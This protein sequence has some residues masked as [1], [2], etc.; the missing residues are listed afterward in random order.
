MI[1]KTYPVGGMGC[2]ACAARVEKILANSNGVIEVAVNYAAATAR[3]VVEDG[4][5]ME[6]VAGAVADGG[7]KLFTDDDRK[8]AAADAKIRNYRRLKYNTLFACL[9]AFP[10]MMI[11]MLWMHSVI[12]LYIQLILSTLV[13]FCFGR[14]FFINSWKQLRHFTCSMDTLVALSTGIA[15]LFS[16]SNMFWPG[17]WLKHGIEPHVYFEAA[18]VIIAFILIGRTL[19]AHAKQTTSA[20]IERLNGLQ[21]DYVTVVTSD[22]T[23]IQRYVS[24]IEPGDVVRILPGEGIPVDGIITQGDSAVDE[25][26]LTGEPIPVEKHVGDR[27]FCGTINGNGTLLCEATTQAGETLLARIIR[28]VED[29]QGTKP[30]VQK[31]VDKIASIFVPT[32]IA[33]SIITF[34]IWMIFDGSTGL[35]H[36]LLAAVTVLIIACPCAL[37]L[38][39]PTALMVGIGRGADMGI[40]IRD[41]ES[42]ETARKVNTVVFDKTG[43]ITEGHPTMQNIAYLNDSESYNINN[44]FSALEQASGHPLANAIATSLGDQMPISEITDIRTIPG[45]G[46]IGKYA[47]TTYIAGNEKLFRQLN[48]NLNPDL[49]SEARRMMDEGMSIVWFGD[50]SEAQAVAGIS[51]EIKNG[52][53][54]AVAKLHSAGIKV[55][56]LTGDNLASARRVARKVGI[57]E[58]KADVLPEDKAKYIETLQSSGHTVA[59][60]GDGINDSAAMA[61]A[62]L[63]IA[64]GTGSDIAMEVA[65]VTI[66]NADLRNVPNSLHLSA[67]TMSTIHQNLFWAFIYNLIGIPIAA[68]ILYPAYGFMLNPM[69]AGAAM[70]FSSVSV[71]CN[72][73]LLRKRKI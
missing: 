43:T 38:A 36:G 22:G 28:M 65:G 10:V 9:F 70:A 66:V 6:K 12:G 53:A 29:A 25:S 8:R 50:N 33:I 16:I 24:L 27:I 13:L 59:M 55:I 31:L 34:I 47:Y 14:Q 72:S 1:E 52:S 46:V 18:A 23:E 19:E 68:G 44:I 15:Y 60:T 30:P 21:P 11:G 2:A 40:L 64:M 26:M 54:Q 4:C 61:V 3:L 7:Y 58:I 63:G 41:A 56:M 73:L 51:D 20:A 71:V 48:I 49:L 37:G 17:F 69:I 62:D 39:T 57:T 35:T 67:A 42:I 45:L 5:D 32:I